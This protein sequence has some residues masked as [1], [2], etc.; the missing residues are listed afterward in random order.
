M[1]SSLRE[2]A[3]L[4]VGCQQFKGGTDCPPVGIQ[5]LLALA[6]LFDV[7]PDIGGVGQDFDYISHRE[8]PLAVSF[9]PDGTNFRQPFFGWIIP[10]SYPHRMHCMP[11]RHS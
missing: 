8:I 1:P 5:L 10:L 11:S 2:S 7:I 4:A 9:I 3:R 6:H